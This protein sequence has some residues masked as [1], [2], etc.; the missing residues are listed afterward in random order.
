[1]SPP[2]RVTLGLQFHRVCCP[3]SVTF[4][5]RYLQCPA[6][7]VTPNIWSLRWTVVQSKKPALPSKCDENAQKNNIRVVDPEFV[8]GTGRCFQVP[9]G[10]QRR[11]QPSRRCRLRH[12]ALLGEPRRSPCLRGQVHQ[13]LLSSLRNPRGQR[14]LTDWCNR[15]EVR[16]NR[17]NALV[18]AFMCNNIVSYLCTV[19]NDQRL[20]S[21]KSAISICIFFEAYCKCQH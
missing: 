3:I 11:L 4:R 14:S 13:R 16:L 21:I 20:M 19:L 12:H 6:S 5:V 2:S 9:R 17:A 18:E 7:G 15:L 10:V 1:M 8:C